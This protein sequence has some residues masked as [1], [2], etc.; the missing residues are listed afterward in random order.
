MVGAYFGKTRLQIGMQLEDEEFEKWKTWAE[1]Q[2]ARIEAQRSQ[3]YSSHG[4]AEIEAAIPEI[5]GEPTE[6]S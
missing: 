2:N 6:S 1:D 3:A 4:Q 5:D